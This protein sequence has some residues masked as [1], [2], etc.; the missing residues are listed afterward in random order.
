[1]KKAAILL[2]IAALTVPASA[3]ELPDDLRQAHAIC[4]QHTKPGRL[5]MLADFEPGWEACR[6]VRIRV[7][8]FIRDNAGGRNQKATESDKAL[9]EKVGKRP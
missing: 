7:N 8:T 2:A 1:M 3:V 4:L 6:Q 5:P 9:V